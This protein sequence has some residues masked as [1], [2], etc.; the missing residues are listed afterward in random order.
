[1]LTFTYFMSKL[2]RIVLPKMKF[3]LSSK[4]FKPED[5]VYLFDNASKLYV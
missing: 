2:E 4:G 5:M 1:M 3:R